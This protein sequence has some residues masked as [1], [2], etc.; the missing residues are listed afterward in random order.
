MPETNENSSQLLQGIFL[1]PKEDGRLRIACPYCSGH[2]SFATNTVYQTFICS[3]CFQEFLLPEELLERPKPSQAIELTPNQARALAADYAAGNLILAQE[4]Q[5]ETA[6][7][8]TEPLMQVHLPNTAPEPPPPHPTTPFPISPLDQPRFP[9][10]EK[11]ESLPPNDWH[12]SQLGQFVWLLLGGDALTLF[13]LVHGIICLLLV[14]TAPLGKPW[15]SRARKS[16]YPFSDAPRPLCLRTSLALAAFTL[17]LKAALLAILVWTAI[18]RLG[19][20]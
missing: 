14:F 7:G 17:T 12:H 18:Y 15:F 6:N 16:L 8:F 11:T 1:G 9:E 19:R 2:F 4:K 10:V 13:C 20:Q 3:N 5:L